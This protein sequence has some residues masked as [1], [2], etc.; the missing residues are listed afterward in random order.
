[1]PT[2]LVAMG[3]DCTG[4]GWAPHF[5]RRELSCR[6]AARTLFTMNEFTIHTPESAPVGSRDTL[7]QL[8]Q[9]VGF[10]PNLA[11]TIAGSPVALGGFVGMQSALR[12][13]SLTP[14]E[15]EI[16]GI[17]VSRENGSP[18]SMAA[19]STFAERV[20]LAPDEIAALRDGGTLADARHEALH[21]FTVELL[22]SRGRLAAGDLLAAGYTPEQVLEVV[23]QVAY[24]TM[25]NFTAGV[26]GTP[27]DAAFEGYA[28]AAA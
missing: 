21:A 17:A 28:W 20:G 26:A 5:S 23:T 16:V 22:R 7:A 24:T 12:G 1:V 25:A 19:H 27:V 15:R 9:N 4:D 8:E 14:A 11:A 13:S 18:Y 2:G 3:G 6:A 10:I